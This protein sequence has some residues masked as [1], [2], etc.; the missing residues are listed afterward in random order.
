LE[1]DMEPTRDQTDCVYQ[2]MVTSRCFEKIITKK[3]REGET[4][5]FNIANAPTSGEMHLS[6]G[7]GSV[8]VGVCH[9]A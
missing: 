9:A 7:Q 2:N 8:A 3:H 5:T 4:P 1:E 6:N